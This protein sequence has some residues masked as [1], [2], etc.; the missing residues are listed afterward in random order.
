MRL[1]QGQKRY[2]KCGNPHQLLELFV[3]EANFILDHDIVSRFG[4]PLKGFVRLKV[5]IPQTL[6]VA[7]DV[8]IYDNTWNWVERAI[9]M[10]A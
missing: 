1:S 9:R 6:P 2:W 4:C 3:A 8:S 5:E 7:S 10:V